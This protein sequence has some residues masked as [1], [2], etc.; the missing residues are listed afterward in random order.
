MLLLVLLVW[1]GLMLVIMLRIAQKVATVIECR[2][3]RVGKMVAIV[4]LCCGR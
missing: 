1:V 4:T 3:H 2:F